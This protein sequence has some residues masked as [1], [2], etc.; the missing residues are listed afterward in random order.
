MGTARRAGRLLKN[1]RL[2]SAAP[3]WA[4][5]AFATVA[6]FAAPARADF[7][8]DLLK[9]FVKRITQESLSRILGDQVCATESAAKGKSDEYCVRIKDGL[10]KSIAG[11]MNRDFYSVSAGVKEIAVTYLEKKYMDW[12]GET[13]FAKELEDFPYLGM[14]GANSEVGIE[15]VV[16]RAEVIGGLVGVLEAL[17]VCVRWIAEAGKGDASACRA[18]V[19][20]EMLA[21]IGWPDRASPDDQERLSDYVSALLAGAQPEL[22]VTGRLIGLFKTTSLPRRIPDLLPH[23]RT[24]VEKQTARLVADYPLLGKPFREGFPTMLR[25]A[26]GGAPCKVDEQTGYLSTFAAWVKKGCPANEASYLKIVA[27]MMFY[28]FPGPAEKDDKETEAADQFVTPLL[29]VAKQLNLIRNLAHALVRDRL[30]PAERQDAALAV[31]LMRRIRI[32]AARARQKLPSA[33]ESEALTGA[34][35]L[36]RLREEGAAMLQSYAEFAGAITNRKDL[37][38]VVD[39]L[40]ARERKYDDA[41]EKSQTKLAHLLWMKNTLRCRHNFEETILDSSSPER[42]V[43]WLRQLPWEV[44]QTLVLATTRGGDLQQSARFGHLVMFH[45]L[46]PTLEVRA[47]EEIINLCPRGAAAPCKKIQKLLLRS[48]VLRSVVWTLRALIEGNL[49]RVQSESQKTLML[50]SAYFYQEI[51]TSLEEPILAALDLTAAA[52]KAFGRTGC[53]ADKAGA[54]RV[55]DDLGRCV[56][57]EYLKALLVFGFDP[58]SWSGRSKAV[59]EKM[60]QGCAAELE[61]VTSFAHGVA[62]AGAERVEK[63][64]R[65]DLRGFANPVIRRVEDLATKIQ[66][67]ASRCGASVNVSGLGRSVAQLSESLASGLQTGARFARWRDEVARR[68]LDELSGSM[69]LVDRVASAAF[70]QGV[71]AARGIVAKFRAEID[72]GALGG[73]PKKRAACKE[74]TQIVSRLEMELARLAV[75]R[76][77][78]G[79]TEDSAASRT[80]ASMDRYQR[81]LFRAVSDSGNVETRFPLLLEYLANTM[82]DLPTFSTLGDFGEPVK[83]YLVRLIRVI[84][85]RSRAAVDRK[86]VAPFGRDVLDLLLKKLFVSNRKPV[87]PLLKAVADVASNQLANLMFDENRDG[88]PEK[89]ASVK[90]GLIDVFERK[91]EFRTTPGLQFRLALGSPFQIGC[92]PGLPCDPALKT[93]YR[94]ELSVDATLACVDGGLFCAGLSIRLPSMIENVT[95]VIEGGDKGPK[96]E[97]ELFQ[98]NTIQGNTLSLAFGPVVRFLHLKEKFPDVSDGAVSRNWLAVGAGVDVT[99]RF[100]GNI[101]AGLRARIMYDHRT[102]IHTDPEWDRVLEVALTLAYGF[103]AVSWGKSP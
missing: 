9:S 84:D 72:A 78:T 61:Y 80:I 38:G 13:T 69:C 6:V 98:R 15:S 16:P 53:D 47:F 31:E 89:L 68:R 90:R 10:E 77:R 73:S 94:E 18:L 81:R 11:I 102:F 7:K 3:R 67:V 65:D 86:F 62:I 93:I 45:S 57:D 74:A 36:K 85:P 48:A 58:A 33:A 96:L 44:A 52:E 75:Q 71:R 63:A 101:L 55:L 27:Q 25:I 100:F 32:L 83:K 79:G 95:R 49:N 50:I 26:I 56:R 97:L 39:A 60:R 64:A 5:V 103:N 4:S 46:G 35:E 43:G 51:S 29:K 42:I 59:V 91:S 54:V 82:Q 34:D 2:R 66:D 99:F 87:P 19:R 23:L 70:G 92:P 1:A 20:P 30:R 21:K 14:K 17:P 88:L 28:A 22:H 24:V 40:K 12:L 8:D 41:L 37:P 76:P